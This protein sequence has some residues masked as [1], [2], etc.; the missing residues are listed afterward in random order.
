MP[1]RPGHQFTTAINE[2]SPGFLVGIGSHWSL[3][4]NPTL[5]F[6]SNKAFQ[7][8]TDQAVT[9]TG[10]AV[11][12]DWVLGG[13]QSYRS[14]STPLAETGAQTDREMFDTGVSASRR[15]G[16]KLST[17]L[18]L[19]QSFGSAQ[20]FTSYKEWSTMDWLNYQVWPRLTLGAGAGYGYVN[21]N[22]G[23][24]SMY[25]Q[26]QGRVN[27]RVTDKISLGLNGGLEDRQFQTGGAGDLLSPIFGASI[28]YQPFAFTQLSLSANKAVSP[29]YFQNQVTENTSIQLGL[30]QR[31]FGRFNFNVGGGY[32]TTKF[33]ASAA[34]FSAG[35]QDDFYFYDARLSCIVRKRGTVAVFYHHSENSSGQSLFTFTSDQVGVEL[36]YHF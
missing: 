9:L 12:G 19:S 23:P 26:Y 6:Y 10:G 20:Q 33:V 32:R 17:D 5:R 7:D 22:V 2:F 24:D 13:S 35:R 25:E 14:S 31:F 36:G 34:G 28:A 16:S 21:M 8:H 18:T 29:S 30:N 11:Y 27:W 15:F 1:A 3:D 4:Y